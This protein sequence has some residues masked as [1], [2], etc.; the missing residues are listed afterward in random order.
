MVGHLTVRQMVLDV[1]REQLVTG[2]MDA[3][4][5]LLTLNR[6]A[7][8]VPASRTAVYNAFTDADELI[9]EVAV[10]AIHDAE[11][12]GYA[13]A[14]EAM[15]SA[16]F[17]EPSAPAGDRLRR[18]LEVNYDQQ[19]VSPA[20][21]AALLLLAAAA[22]SSDEWR[23]GKPRDAEAVALGR[24]LLDQRR[25]FYD[26]LSED[27]LFMLAT[28]M[29]DLG[30]RP[31]V[32]V[33][34]KT[35][36]VLLHCLFDGATLRRLSDPESVPPRLVAD[37]IL[38]LGVAMGEHGV[39]DD[40]RMPPVEASASRR[41]FDD[42]IEAAE[43]MCRTDGLPVVAAV[44]SAADVPLSTAEALFRSDADLYDSLVRKHVVGGGFRPPGRPDDHVTA[45]L[46]LHTLSAQLLRYVDVAEELPGL[47]EACDR[48]QPQSSNPVL[49][50]LVTN[51]AAGIA[52]IEGVRDAAQLVTDMFR[53]A[54][55]GRANLP[56]IEALLRTAGLQGDQQPRPAD[57]V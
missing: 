25:A 3:L 22:S 39:R 28:A 53:L 52:S 48:M 6:L 12:G 27:F 54:A 20:F 29:S 33:D 11:W 30:L 9:R 21:P 51:A 42:L 24:E 45:Q 38:M 34:R 47:L 1:A 2:G 23:G 56:A 35:I 50:D 17:N 49:K 37:A 40:P 5:A 7:P 31:R 36:V 55:G 46:H 41:A 8:Y 19:L 13:G 44:A 57:P 26:K 16:Y 18:A 43:T 14:T 32:D 15:V 10:H 4:R